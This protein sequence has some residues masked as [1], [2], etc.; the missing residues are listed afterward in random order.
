[1]NQSLGFGG[2]AHFSFVLL[3]KVRH[4]KHILFKS[5][6]HYHMSSFMLICCGGKFKAVMMI[7]WISKGWKWKVSLFSMNITRLITVLKKWPKISHLKHAKSLKISPKIFQLNFHAK[8]HQQVFRF[9]S[10]FSVKSQ[11]NPHCFVIM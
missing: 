3:W 5:G 8:N 9:L 7:W 4:A 11:E 2:R 10:K 6:K 1:M